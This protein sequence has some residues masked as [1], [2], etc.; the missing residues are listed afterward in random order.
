MLEDEVEDVIINLFSARGV[1]EGPNTNF[2]CP[3]LPPFN[4]A[5][6]P[7]PVLESVDITPE[8]NSCQMDLAPTT[9]RQCSMFTYSHLRPFQGYRTGLETCTVPGKWYL[10]HHNDLTVV[11]ESQALPDSTLTQLTMV[12]LR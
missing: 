2:D 12:S 10:I 4:F 5:L 3:T 1:C 8:I 6:D 9:M 7:S 11:V